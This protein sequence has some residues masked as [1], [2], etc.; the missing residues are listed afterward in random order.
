[1]PAAGYPLISG[2]FRDSATGRTHPLISGEVRITASLQ[3]TFF[4]SGEFIISDTV[5][6]L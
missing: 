1:M 6:I 5:H 3:D 4:I 2:E